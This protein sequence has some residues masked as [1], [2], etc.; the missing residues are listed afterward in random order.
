MSGRSQ[1]LTVT[2]WYKG[3]YDAL[4]GAARW[5][6]AAAIFKSQAVSIAP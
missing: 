2:S 5:V 1:V 6:G 4:N 3:F